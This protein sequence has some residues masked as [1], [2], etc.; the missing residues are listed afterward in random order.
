MSLGKS[1]LKSESS[2]RQIPLTIDGNKL[3]GRG[4]TSVRGW[5]ARG[6]EIESG[7]QA[8]IRSRSIATSLFSVALQFNDLR[9]IRFP[10]TI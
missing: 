6:L 5:F 8:Q 9:N 1:P 2:V 4:K 7:L 10:F 3:E